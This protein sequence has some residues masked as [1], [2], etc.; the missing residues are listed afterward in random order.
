ML[1]DS[2]AKRYAKRLICCDR[3]MKKRLQE[4]SRLIQARRAA[5]ERVER[6]FFKRFELLAVISAAQN[7]IE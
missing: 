1:S 7:A 4:S 2:G 6:Y 3:G 5:G